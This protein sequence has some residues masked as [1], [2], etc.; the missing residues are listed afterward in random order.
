MAQFW[1]RLVRVR[2]L[3]R[4]ENMGHRYALIFAPYF[5]WESMDVQV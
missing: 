2:D 1:F 3:V 4:E 5:S